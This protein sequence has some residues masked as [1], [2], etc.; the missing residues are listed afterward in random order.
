VVIE[1]EIRI[2]RA[3]PFEIPAHPLSIRSQLAVWSPRNSDHGYVSLVQ[4]HNYSIEIVSPK[5]AMQ[6]CPPPTQDQ[7]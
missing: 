5:G 6:T 4:V 2:P 1:I 7:T 3:N